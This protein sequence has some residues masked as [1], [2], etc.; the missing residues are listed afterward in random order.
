MALSTLKQIPVRKQWPDEAKDFT[1]WLASKNGLA[2]L[3]ETLGMELELEDTEVWVGNYR[4][5]IVAK[6]TLTNEYVVIENQLTATNHDH[7]GKL[8]TYS[9]SFG[10]TTLVWTAERLREE[11]R[12][13]IDWFNDITTDNIDFYGIE[14]ELCLPRI[15]KF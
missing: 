12:Q 11:H 3:S 2:L 9:A 7:I 5:D 14:I 8:F 15:K 6:D 1:P 13:A 4:A 10:A